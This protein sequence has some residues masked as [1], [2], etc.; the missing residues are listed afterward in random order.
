MK[1]E[2]EEKFHFE[3]RNGGARAWA[4]LNNFTE[5]EAWKGKEDL[6]FPKRSLQIYYSSTILESWRVTK[7]SLFRKSREGW[8]GDNHR[9]H[10]PAWCRVNTDKIWLFN[11]I[12]HWRFELTFVYFLPIHIKKHTNLFKNVHS[13]LRLNV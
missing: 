6:I 2:Y 8:R 13:S 11:Q 9:Q 12:N 4:T 7:C 3:N 10:R 5:A 1:R